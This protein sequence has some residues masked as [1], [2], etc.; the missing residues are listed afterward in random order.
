M[1]KA[2]KLETPPPVWVCKYEDMSK[3][4]GLAFMLSDGRSGLTFKDG[5]KIVLDTGGAFFEYVDGG[6]NCDIGRSSSSNR[7]GSSMKSDVKSTL[8]FRPSAEGGEGEESYSTKIAAS[9]GTGIAGSADTGLE[10]RADRKSNSFEREK[11]KEQKEQTEQR[12]EEERKQGQCHWQWPERRIMHTLDDYPSSIEKKVAIAK[13]VQEHLGRTDSTLAGGGGGGSSAETAAA[14]R[15][16]KPVVFVD[17]WKRT[18]SSWVF[19]LSNRTLQVSA[20]RRAGGREG[21]TGT[22]PPS[23]V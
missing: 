14:T 9:P 16:A 12:E 20:L 18:R 15:A 2:V 4:Y 10:A 21:R 17:R 11:Q 1:A 3:K 6:R 22:Y 5:T 19:C 8:A 13:K 23:H 7:G